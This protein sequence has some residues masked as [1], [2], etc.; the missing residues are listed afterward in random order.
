M[1]N[2]C[3]DPCLGNPA[4]STEASL[5]GERV[6]NKYEFVRFL[7]Y[8][9]VGEGGQKCQKIAYVFCERSD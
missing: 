5:F 1:R 9:K 3:L 4:L 2:K 6:K 7:H 8:E